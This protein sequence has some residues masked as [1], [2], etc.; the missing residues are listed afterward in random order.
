VA[1]HSRKKQKK[2]GILFHKFRLKK[3][4][5]R[6]LHFSHL[7]KRKASFRGNFHHIWKDIL[8]LGQFFLSS[9]DSLSQTFF[10]NVINSGLG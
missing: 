3:Y 8:V 6:F 2:R 9:F 10:V 7:K 1:K 4:I 5:Q